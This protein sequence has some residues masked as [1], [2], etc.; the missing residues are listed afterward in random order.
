MGV[1]V[2]VPPGAPFFNNFMIAR[3][4][5]S[6]LETAIKLLWNPFLNFSQKFLRKN[7]P[8]SRRMQEAIRLLREDQLS[9]ESFSDTQI[10]EVLGLDKVSD[11]KKLLNG[12]DE[13]SFKL[14]DQFSD[15]Y[16][17]NNNWLKHGESSP[18]RL[19]E[20]PLFTDHDFIS[21]LQSH[22]PEIIYFVR[23]DSEEA[24][25][26]IV[27]KLANK[28]YVTYPYVVNLSSHVGGTGR[29][30]LARFHEFLKFVLHEMDVDGA[31][32][33]TIPRKEFD[34]LSWGNIYP[35]KLLNNRR[36]SS[37]H[38]WDDFIFLYE[39]DERKNS[40]IEA[41]GPEFVKAQDIVREEQKKV[42]TKPAP[43]HS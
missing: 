9:I 3:M 21:E 14:L 2:Q 18:F 32:G 26:T 10:A 20:S 22:E 31:F 43:S 39:D 11:L 1:G 7:A 4:I 37:N 28:K 17:L 30:Q 42:L 23:N 5:I 33:R 12:T 36:D 40:F 6:L 19:S 41:Y 35:G 34:E 27:M 8:I 15:Y 24:E 38:W 16:G 25:I 13:P 29:M